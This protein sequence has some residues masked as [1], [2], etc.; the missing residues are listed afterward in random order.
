MQ[1]CFSKP[2]TEIPPGLIW[3][4][5]RTRALLRSHEPSFSISCGG[6]HL[7]TAALLFWGSQPSTWS[8]A[9]TTWPVKNGSR[10]P[11]NSPITARAT[12]LVCFSVPNPNSQRRKSIYPAWSNP[13]QPE[14]G[15]RYLNIASSNALLWAAGRR[16]G[17]CELHRRP[18]RC[19]L[20]S[21]SSWAREPTSN[22][23]HHKSN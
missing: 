22:Q 2:I 16:G 10:H 18:R 23:H 6:F 21:G 9:Q 12:L 3:A 19:P 1:R 14:G 4:W 20:L 5:T 11:P 17:E 7:S 13:V 8:S 15:A